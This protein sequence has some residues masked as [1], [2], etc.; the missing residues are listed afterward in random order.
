MKQITILVLALIPAFQCALAQDRIYRCGSDYVNASAGEEAK[1][2]NCKL[3]SGGRIIEAPPPKS[4]RNLSKKE[5]D[6]YHA[7]LV[8]ATKAP[9]TIGVKWG[10][11]LCDSKFGQ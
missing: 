2:S 4:K 5:L 7:C 8:D 9:T 11:D 10:S 3:I 6:K 1:Y